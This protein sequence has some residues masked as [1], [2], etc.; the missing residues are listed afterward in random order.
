MFKIFKAEVKYKL[1]KRIK[2]VQS[3][4]GGEYYDKYGGSGEQRLG[5][6]AKFQEILGIVPQYTMLGSH[7]MNDVAK[8]QNCG[9]NAFQDYFD[10][11]KESREDSIK[12][13][14]RRVF[15]KVLN[16]TILFKRK[17]LPKSFTLW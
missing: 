3:D 9:S 7:S 15:Q 1:N 14:I 6:F 4:H 5:P 10:D 13:S 16:S 11:A 12:I 2:N 8:R 17:I